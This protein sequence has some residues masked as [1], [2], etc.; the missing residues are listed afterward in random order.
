MLLIAGAATLAVAGTLGGPDVEA[1]EQLW[2]G[3]RD[4]SE[5]VFI[6]T[7]GGVTAWT[8][9]SERRVRTIVARVNAPWLG[10]HVLY[11]EEFLHDNPDH[12]R[13]QL[14]LQLD[15][16]LP[17]AVGVHVRLYT[18]TDPQRWAHLN[19]RPKLLATLSRHE[20]VES[21]GCDLTL[22]REGDQFRGGTVGHECVD[23][24][25]GPARYVDFQ[26]VISEDLYWY[27]RR[28][29]LKSGDDLQEELIG[30]N[31]FELNEAR[32]FTCRI[33]WSSSG[34]RADLRPLVKLDLHDQGG[35]ARFLTPDGRRLELTLHSQDWPF[36]IDRD[37]LILLV[38][39]QAES[40]PLASAWTEIDAT[41]ISVS[42]GWLNVRCGSIAP[43]GEELWSNVPEAPTHRGGV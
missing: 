16:P 4:S 30:F 6:N 20:V 33:E 32:L 41:Q 40:E 42:L 5:E 36:M 12:V 43:S 37:A 17:P 13:R 11:L 29:L 1:L 28:V 2:P 35:R 22:K 38:Q 3:V 8:E 23:V 7:D 39:D 31:W 18:F 19:R 27:R 26:L 10:P 24:R 15:P 34:R 21:K 9:G 25:K 14:L